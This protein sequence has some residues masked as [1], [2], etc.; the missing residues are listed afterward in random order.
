MCG[1]KQTPELSVIVPLYNEASCLEQNVSQ[2]LFYLEACATSYEIVLVNDGSTDATGAICNRLATDNPSIR[3][4]SSTVNRGKGWAVKT[5]MLEARGKYAVFTDADLAVP[6]Q[7]LG[8]LLEQLKNGASV[9]IASRHLPESSF[10][11]RE[12]FLRRLFGETF[13]RVTRIILGLRVT[14][15]TCGFKGFN[16]KAFCNIFARSMIE[17][18]GYDAEIIFLAQKLEY[19][20]LEIPVEWYHS[21][22][23]KVKVGIDSIRTIM[24][25]LCIIRYH[26]TNRYA[27]QD[28]KV[29]RVYNKAL[30]LSDKGTDHSSVALPS[31]DKPSEFTER[32]GQS[33]S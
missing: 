11:I 10:E 25:L 14:D 24:E 17:G 19:T 29:K 5:G 9:V 12:G 21:F 4:I 20:I 28:T 6:I 26:K 13:R 3:T 33:V 27:L 1:N 22:D 23:S 7:F 15:I 32:S 16:R 30:D 2:V 8:S 31:P 18:W